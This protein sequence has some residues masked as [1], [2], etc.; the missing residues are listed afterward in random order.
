ML[1][2]TRIIAKVKRDQPEQGQGNLAEDA[3][4][5]TTGMITE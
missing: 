1:N 2:L 5:F 4:M 3:V